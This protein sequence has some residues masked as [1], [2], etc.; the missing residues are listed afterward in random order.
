MNA[1]FVNDELLFLDTP[2]VSGGYIGVKNFP[3][4]SHVYYFNVS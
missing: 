4:V 3:P 1:L 2:I